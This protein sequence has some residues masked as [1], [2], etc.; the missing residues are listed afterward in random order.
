MSRERREASR[1]ME[2]AAYAAGADELNKLDRPQG[3]SSRLI[4]DG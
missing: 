2:G 4:L 3:V 1:E